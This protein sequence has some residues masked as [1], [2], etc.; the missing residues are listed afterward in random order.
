M[1]N[2]NNGIYSEEEKKILEFISNNVKIDINKIDKDTIIEIDK[3]I[4]NLNYTSK[5]ILKESLIKNIKSLEIDISS[6]ISII[7]GTT[8]INVICIPILLEYIKIPI[9]SKI[10]HMIYPIIVLIIVIQVIYIPIAYFRDKDQL[11]FYNFLLNRLNK[12][13]S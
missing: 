10:V 4:N 6:Y 1:I 3:Y 8:S 2:K 13:K 9:L 5:D 7:I 11:L 12:N